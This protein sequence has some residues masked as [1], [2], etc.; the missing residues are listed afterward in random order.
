MNFYPID[1]LTPMSS[2]KNSQF[3][4]QWWVF[5]QMIKFPSIN[6]LS[7][8]WYISITVLNFHHSNDFSLQWWIFFTV[9]TFHPRDENLFQLCFITSWIFSSNWRIFDKKFFSYSTYNFSHFIILFSISKLFTIVLFGHRRNSPL[10]FLV[11]D[12]H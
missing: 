12:C 2:H 10:S 5:H 6:E 8:Y 7:A 3:S 1:I 4:S 9:I 11:H